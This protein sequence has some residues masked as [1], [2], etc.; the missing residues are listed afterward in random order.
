LR[1]YGDRKE[2]EMSKN[3][4]TIN[5]KGLDAPFEKRPSLPPELLTPAAQAAMNH[6]TSEMVR[7]L[8]AQLAPLLKD[9]SLSPEKLALMEELRRAPTADQAAAAARSK[10]EKALTLEEADQNRKNLK[11]SQENCLHRYV[12]GALSVSAIR[13]Y[14]DRQSRYVCHKCLAIFQPRRWEI[15]APNSA[16]PRGEERIV[17]ADPLYL[18]IAKE[19]HASHE[20]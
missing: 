7:E 11:L 20:S 19:W 12:S 18:Q 17:D 10:R 5:L 13:N 3:E 16:F 14:P 2:H 1:R 8:F 9:I 4:E 15:L 6:N